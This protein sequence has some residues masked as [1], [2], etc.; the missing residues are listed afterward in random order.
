MQGT[1]IT[2]L[3][4]PSFIVTLAGYLIANG[5]FLWILDFGP[6]SG[7]PNL[8]GFSD[9]LHVVYNLMWGTIDPTVSWILAAAVVLGLGSCMW[10]SDQRRRPSGLV[11]PPP[12]LT[13]ITIGLIAV[14]AA[15]VV[16]L[17]AANRGQR[18]PLRRV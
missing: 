15:V 10:V 3:R 5:L 7:Y 8:A 13:L 16:A 9:S 12:S 2:R 11:A 14:V 6:F 17:C 1:L 4:L 18:A